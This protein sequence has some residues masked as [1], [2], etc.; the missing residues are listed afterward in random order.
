MKNK[1]VSVFKVVV[2]IIVLFIT[3]YNSSS[4]TMAAILLNPEKQNVIF[5]NH[6]DT[7]EGAQVKILSAND[8][9]GSIWFAPYDTKTFKVGTTMTTANGTAASIVAPVKSGEYYLFYIDGSR[10]ISN[11]SNAILSVYPSNVFLKINKGPSN[12]FVNSNILNI[13][14]SEVLISGIESMYSD[15]LIYE[16]GI[17]VSNKGGISISSDGMD[18][19]TSNS[20]VYSQIRY[21]EERF[22][23]FNY[24]ENRI[25][26]SDDGVNWEE[27]HIVG[28]DSIYSLSYNDGIYLA[29]GSCKSKSCIAL[30]SDFIIWKF[31]PLPYTV[32]SI[33]CGNGV[34]VGYNNNSLVT[35][36]DGMNWKTVKTLSGT[37][38]FKINFTGG[39]FFVPKSNLVSSD[40]INWE[41][42]KM[43][44]SMSLPIQQNGLF[45][46][47]PSRNNTLNVSFDGINWKLI[48]KVTGDKNELLGNK[49]V[50][51]GKIYNIKTEN[52]L[53]ASYGFSVDNICDSND[54]Y[55]NSFTSG[56][57]FTLTGNRN[58]Y[59]CV[60]AVSK[61]GEESYHLVG[62][63]FLKSSKETCSFQSIKSCDRVGLL[64]LIKSLIQTRQ[65]KK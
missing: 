36:Q 2:L 62:Q 19:R 64:S 37:P 21:L 4:V 46:M 8:P 24:K 33:S 47:S 53:N 27:R 58:D 41:R 57:D 42:V 7:F 60:K 28:I 12:G 61:S 18:W 51:N 5:P 6:L 25:L 55:N 14:L 29:S 10:K 59:L 52:V 13:S 54:I 38:N 16:K 34:C 26:F 32:E 30:S 22:F 39:L 48:K 15:N 11:P 49:V 63:L 35:S 31:Y 40:G 44:G 3:I 23:A 17:F 1:L 43:D 45:I 56:V 65:A 50:L 9:N 20:F